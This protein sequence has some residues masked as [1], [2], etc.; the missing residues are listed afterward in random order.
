M[1][2]D[3]IHNWSLPVHYWCLGPFIALFMEKKYFVQLKAHSEDTDTIVHGMIIF[4][5]KQS[6]PFLSFQSKYSILYVF[7]LIKPGKVGE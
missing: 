2:R 6:L 7:F 4:L 5:I 3:V 1:K